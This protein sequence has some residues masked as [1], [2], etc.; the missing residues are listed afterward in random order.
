MTLFILGW[1][2]LQ[3]MA[4]ISARLSLV[5]GMLLFRLRPVLSSHTLDFF[6]SPTSAKSTQPYDSPI[7]SVFILSLIFFFLNESA[8]E[9]TSYCLPDLKPLQFMPNPE[10]CVFRMGTYAYRS[11]CC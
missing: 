4:V 9:G 11:W 10:F 3:L 2:G 7:G 6:T 5:D 1:T 8:E